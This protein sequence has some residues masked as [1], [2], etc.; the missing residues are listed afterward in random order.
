MRERILLVDYS[1]ERLDQLNGRM[2]N[3]FAK[4]EIIPILTDR[5][6]ATEGPG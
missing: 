6:D 4:V 2:R 3:R 1:K 5:Y